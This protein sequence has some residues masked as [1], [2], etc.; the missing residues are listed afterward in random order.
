M[1]QAQ[2]LSDHL[3][4]L[5]VKRLESGKLVLPVMPQA[6]QRVQ[7]Q[8]DDPRASLK[9]LAQTIESDP[10]LAA[11]VLQAA[12]SAAFGFATPVKSISQA[13]TKL[14]IRN[15]RR[16][17]YTAIA[18]RVFSSRLKRANEALQVLWEHS[19]AVAV[20]SQDI[21]GLV[22]I[23]DIQAAYT[24]GLLHDIGQ[25]VVAV[26]LLEVER[27]LLNGAKSSRDD[28]IDFPAWMN[29]VRAS[30]APIGAA[31][32][33]HWRLPEDVCLAIANANDYD[34]ANRLCISNVVRFADAITA[35]AGITIE[36]A[37][38]SNAQARMMIGRSLLDVEEAMV[39][40]LI[41]Q[42]DVRLKAS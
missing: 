32:A 8:L 38:A 9:Q 31:V 11:Q 4:A 2:A 5:V 30:Q 16:L 39:Q 13:L 28:F 18:Q 21:A 33:K 35:V 12:N 19:L 3:Q 15:I 14:G 24:A 10:V 36:D 22:G 20:L 7:T 42:I 1:I 17:L 29:I 25:A 23:E 27:T 6:A 37:D 26:Y 40:R 34:P 41:G